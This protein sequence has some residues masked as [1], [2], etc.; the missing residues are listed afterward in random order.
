MTNAK[1]LSLSYVKVAASLAVAMGIAVTV[2]ARP[3]HAQTDEGFYG[4]LK[5]GA[6]ALSDM[7]YA[8][9]PNSNLDLDLGTGWV[10]GGSLGYRFASGFRTE[11]SIDY[12]DGSLDGTYR[13]NLFTIPCGTL[14]AQPC[15]GPG[16]EGDVTAWSGFAM[17]YYDINLDSPLKPYVG[18][19]LGVVRTGLDVE[20]R[21]RLN[22]GTSSDFDI[23]DDK[24]NE[25]A[26]RVAAGVAY[27]LNPAATIDIGYTFTRTGRPALEGR[28]S[29]VPAFTFDSRL[30]SHAVTAGV[31]L[32]F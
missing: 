2:A 30:K 4:S 1:S 8:N 25:F 31:R 23:I 17:A 24:D 19:G 27:E 14:A 28:G 6:A 9:G 29:A 15:L 10:I 26:Y 3:A 12:L 32:N 20:T 11:L 22:N 16:V 21:A 5:S 13:E 7:N 18:G